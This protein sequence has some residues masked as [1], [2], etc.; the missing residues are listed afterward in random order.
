MNIKL[1]IVTLIAAG[2]CVSCGSSHLSNTPGKEVSEVV[3]APQSPLSGARRAM[4]RAVIYRTNGNFNSNVS[5]TYDK[6]TLSFI[7]FP[8]PSDVSL[9]SEP[10]EL[11]DGWLLDRRGGISPNTVFLRWTYPEYHALPQTP[12]IEQLFQA[13]IPGA[14]VIQIRILD[15]TTFAA[16][17]DTASV[18]LLIKETRNKICQ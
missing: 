10:I 5:A 15:M 18:N 8:A 11:V 17:A 1:F 13:I 3:Y 6:S 14:E 16:Q 9:D 4:P 2:T 12:S 7:S